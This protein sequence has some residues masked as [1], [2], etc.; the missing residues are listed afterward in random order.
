MIK[1][2]IVTFIVALA[3]FIPT[4]VKAAVF[5]DNQVVGEYKKWTIHFNK[6]VKFDNLSKQGVVVTDSKGNKVATQIGALDEY[7]MIVIY[8]PM[9]G[10]VIGEKY[11]LTVNNKLRDLD[12]NSIKQSICLNFKVEPESKDSVVFKNKLLEE[13]IR[14]MINKWEGDLLKSDIDKITY[15]TFLRFGIDD[16]SEIGKLSNLKEIDLSVRANVS[17]IDGLKSL[18]HLEKLNLSGNNVRDISPIS[19]LNNLKVLDLSDTPVEDI[20]ELSGVTN[21][22]E[23]S[24]N[25]TDVEDISG[26]KGLTNLQRLELSCTHVKDISALRGLTNLQELNLGTTQVED[27]S[28]LKGLTN[29]QELN[30]GATQV[31]DITALKDVPNLKYVGLSNDNI[32][33]LSVIKELK[34]LKE[35]SLTDCVMKDLSAIKGSNIEELWINRDQANDID[36]LKGLKNL[37]H[38]N[39]KKL[40]TWQKLRLQKELSNCYI[41]DS[42]WE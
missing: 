16:I 15:M 2:I 29:L 28:A 33:D 30:I 12:D 1:K 39:V 14:Y 27:I 22:K 24:L 38:L 13:N 23:L 19:K 17:N 37:K 32:K 11:Q 10:Y 41:Q 3:L 18:T 25:N 40:E 4:N 31:E 7:K 21:L 35:L 8:P 26:L 36:T 42:T 6:E 5:K 9:G 34:N 20:S